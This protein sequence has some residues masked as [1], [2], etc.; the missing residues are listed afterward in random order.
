MMQEFRFSVPSY[1]ARNCTEQVQL[2][3]ALEFREPFVPVLI[4]RDNGVRVVL[5]SHEY[6]EMRQPD[7]YIERQPKGWLIALHPSAGGDPS[8]YVYFLDDGRSF[9]VKENVVG[10]T[11]PIEVLD[12]HERIPE[13]DG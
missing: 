8:G 2:R 11:V 1:Q 5:G 6:E 4:R 12:C 7:V 10:S 3:E 13:I 9:L